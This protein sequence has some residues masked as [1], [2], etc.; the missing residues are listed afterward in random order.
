MFIWHNQNFGNM[1]KLFYIPLML[2]MIIGLNNPLKSQVQ[3]VSPN[4]GEQWLN[5]SAESIIWNNQGSYDYFTIEY[6]ED[7]GNTWYTLAY[8]TGVPGQNE[9]SIVSNFNATEL[10]KIRISDYLDPSVNDE[11]DGTFTVVNPPFQVYSPYWGQS[12]YQGTDIYVGWFSYINAA[13]DI[14][15]SSDNGASW[16]RI[17]SN[18]NSGAFTFAAP[19]LVSGECLVRVSDVNNP[20]LFGLSSQFSIL[21]IPEINTVI[22]NGGETW[23]YGNTA[24]VS[25]SGSGISTYVYIEFSPDNGLSWQSLSYAYSAPGGGTAQVNV[26]YAQTNTARIRVSDPYF[27]GSGAVSEEAFTVLVPPYLINAPYAGQSYY[28]LQPIPVSWYSYVPAETNI[29]IT[30]DNGNSFQLVAQ[31]LA[32]EVTYYQVENDHLPTGQAFIRLANSNDTTRFSDSPVFSIVQA[33]E[34]SLINPNGGELLDQNSFFNIRWSYSGTVPEY[35]YI[36]IDYSTDN[37]LSWTNAGIAFNSGQVTEYT[38]DVPDVDSDSCLIRI[39]DYL[40]PFISAS[41][42]SVFSIKD[43][44]EINICMVSVDSL[45]GKNVIAWETRDNALIEEYLVLKETE[46]ADNYVE[47]GRVSKN[48]PGFFTDETSD[49]KVKATRYKV[50]FR[51][52]N[53]RQYP[54]GTLHQTIHLTISQGV[55]NSWNLIWNPY[56]GFPVST[57]RIYRSNGVENME[58]IGTTSGNFT[59]FTDYSAES[60]SVYYMVEVI[61]PNPCNTGSLKSG[62]TERSYSNIASYIVNDSDDGRSTVDLALYP[63][64][65]SEHLRVRADV[66]YSPAIT[67]SILDM[68]GRTLGSFNIS[69]SALSNGYEIPVSNLGSGV[70]TLKISSPEFTGMKRFIKR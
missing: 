42:S 28:T 64:P 15:F 68:Q 41:S 61:N 55:G 44:P 16:T 10:A 66:P 2:I 45:S 62:T 46:I 35:S 12:Y 50:A 47:I 4:G 52:N 19:Q 58:L 53:D 51:D 5:G 57:Y 25:W 43:I 24:D 27:F 33:P 31:G 36:N 70:Y 11:S 37:G 18:N 23:M 22:P 7:N 65:A 26:P 1:K 40:Y 9:Y 56:L 14:D 39:S 6:S 54:A 59:S 13:V 67:V 38:W 17:S 20:L 29:Y 32:P 60:G 69:S 30:Y 48:E 63:N 3:V 21:A 49:P 34:L 8:V